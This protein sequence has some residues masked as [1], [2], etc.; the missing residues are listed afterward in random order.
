MFKLLS[1]L[2]RRLRGLCLLA[3][4]RL[5]AQQ[6][7]RRPR[8]AIEAEGRAMAFEDTNGLGTVAGSVLSYVPVTTAFS[9]GVAFQ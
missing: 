8:R 3:G 6:R 2:E 5:C 4:S 9:S 1:D 7:E